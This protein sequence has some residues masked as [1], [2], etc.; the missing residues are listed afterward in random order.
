[1]RS[2]CEKKSGKNLYFLFLYKKIKKIN[3]EK[4]LIWRMFFVYLHAR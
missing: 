2:K 1:M 3:V 4:V